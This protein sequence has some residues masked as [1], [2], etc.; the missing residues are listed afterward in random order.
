MAQEIQEANFLQKLDRNVFRP[1][2]YQAYKNNLQTQHSL[3][4]QLKDQLSNQQDA[5]G[6]FKNSPSGPEMKRQIQNTAKDLDDAET[7]VNHLQ[8]HGLKALKY[9]PHEMEIK[10][11]KNKA[12]IQAGLGVSGAYGAMHVANAL[13]E[14]EVQESVGNAALVGGLALGGAAL[15]NAL[16]D[17][18]EQVIEK[19]IKM[20]PGNDVLANELGDFAKRY[21]G[22]GGALA[23]VGIANRLNKLK[24]QV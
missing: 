23:G 16:G 18:T 17:E 4:K 21:S 1:G 12:R 9:T 11:A 3:S 22:V 10:Q 20:I 15:A 2:Q 7:Q 6:R 5:Y 8:T 13:D 19:P 14:A 24:P